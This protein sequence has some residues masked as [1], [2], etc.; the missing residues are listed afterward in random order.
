MWSVGGGW[1]Y[2]GPSLFEVGDLFGQTAEGPR[3]K[4]PKP[5]AWRCSDPSFGSQVAEALEVPILDRQYLCRFRNS[6][7]CWTDGSRRGRHHCKGGWGLALF[8]RGL[9]TPTAAEVRNPRNILLQGFGPMSLV[10]DDMFFAGA[11]TITNGTAELNAA[12]EM[13]FA[14]LDLALVAKRRVAQEE[15]PCLG[16]NI[17]VHL[18]ATYVVGLC[19]NK[20]S[21]RENIVMAKLVKHLWREVGKYFMLECVWTKAHAN[22]EAN[23][24]VDLLAKMGTEKSNIGKFHTRPFVLDS[25][26]CATEFRAGIGAATNAAIL[27]CALFLESKVALKHSAVAS[28]YAGLQ[29]ADPSNGRGHRGGRIADNT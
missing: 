29:R 13:L 27:S 25:E 22:N 8:K 18:D 24:Y 20:F 4:T 12:I 23:N 26:W 11:T 28:Y 15:K 17:I 16:D 7:H 14:L 19:N 2:L 5:I 10:A 6:F 1:H 21:I 9:H 3:E